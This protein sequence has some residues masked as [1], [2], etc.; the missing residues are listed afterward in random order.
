[1][2]AHYTTF[3][4]INKIVRNHSHMQL[5]FFLLMHVFGLWVETGAPPVNH[6]ERTKPVALENPNPG[7]SNYEVTV[8]QTYG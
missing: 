7:H 8:L 5:V 3:I 6:T 2:V 1:M 4:N